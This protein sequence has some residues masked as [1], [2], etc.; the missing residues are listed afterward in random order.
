MMIAE[1][2]LVS[3]LLTRNH[4]RLGELDEA[5]LTGTRA[6]EIAAADW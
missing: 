1:R 5:L 4:T 3:A 6:L 2:G